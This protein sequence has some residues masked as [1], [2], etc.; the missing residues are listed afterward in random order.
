MPLRTTESPGCRC[1]T[2]IRFSSNRPRGVGTTSPAPTTARSPPPMAR[3][4]ELIVAS[5]PLPATALM[6]LNACSAPVLPKRWTRAPARSKISPG[7]WALTS[8]V[9]CTSNSPPRASD[10]VLAETTSDAVCRCSRGPTPCVRKPH[11]E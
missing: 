3:A 10:G 9:A 1:S 6:A 5:E 7:S 4:T 2:C 8:T 11:K